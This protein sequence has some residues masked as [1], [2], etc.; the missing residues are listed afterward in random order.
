MQD[1]QQLSQQQQKIKIQ[2]HT[3][4]YRDNEDFY[5]FDDVGLK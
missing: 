3:E 2:T 5:K 1:L 4:Y